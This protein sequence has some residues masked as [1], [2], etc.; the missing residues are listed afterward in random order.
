MKCPKCG[1]E[2]IKI[3]DSRS[4]DTLVY[5]IRKCLDCEYRFGTKE[6]IV[7]YITTLSEIRKIMKEKY[8]K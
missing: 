8:N 4:A 6:S 3:I 7:E 1:S 5:R 2:N